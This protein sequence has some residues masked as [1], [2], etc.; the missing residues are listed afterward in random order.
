MGFNSA[1]KGLKISTGV[2]CLGRYALSIP[3]VFISMAQQP[4]VGQGLLIME[5]L[6][7]HSDIPHSVELLRTSNQ[8]DADTY[9]WQHPALTRKKY[10]VPSGI[11][12]RNPSKRAA[13]DP[14]L[15]PHGHLNRPPIITSNAGDTVNWMM[16]LVVYKWFLLCNACSRNE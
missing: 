4:L 16:V 5:A 15:K 1:F 10:P 2:Y 9:T 3:T 8:P 12:I 7:W 6:W 13:A 14:R 11:R